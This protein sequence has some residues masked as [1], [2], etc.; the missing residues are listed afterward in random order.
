MD[1][2]VNLR[3]ALQDLARCSTAHRGIYSVNFLHPKLSYI[4]ESLKNPT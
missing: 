3:I 1:E 4:L 2:K